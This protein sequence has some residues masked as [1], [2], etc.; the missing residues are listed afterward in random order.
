MAQYKVLKDADVLQ[1]EM[2]ENKLLEKPVIKGLALSSDSIQ[3]FELFKANKMYESENL[4]MEDS[5]FYLKDNDEDSEAFELK[6]KANKQYRA[7]ANKGRTVNRD[8]S[9][10]DLDIHSSRDF[11]E[12]IGPKMNNNTKML[13][14]SNTLV[15]DALDL[16]DGD[17]AGN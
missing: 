17:A 9:D 1:F 8:N 15:P 10:Q 16:D 4:S 7:K 11:W 5:E 14:F 12:E 3:K 2:V 6:R 13:D